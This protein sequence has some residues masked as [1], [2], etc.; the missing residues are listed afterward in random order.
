MFYLADMEARG[1]GGDPD[2]AGAYALFVR[3][4][5]LGLDKAQAAAKEIEPALT[6]ADRV[7]AHQM[8]SGVAR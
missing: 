4:Q 5:R 8:L 3:A 6:A 2:I 1:E 7:K